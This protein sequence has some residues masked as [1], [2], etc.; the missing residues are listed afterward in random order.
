MFEVKNN[1]GISTQQA[2]YTGKIE[3]LYSKGFK[4][5]FYNSCYSSKQFNTASEALEQYEAD[6]IRFNY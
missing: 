3:K 1:N 5:Y 6:K 4:K 2:L